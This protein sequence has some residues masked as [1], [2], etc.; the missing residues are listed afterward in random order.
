[1]T[2]GYGAHNQKSEIDIKVDVNLDNKIWI[3]D[4]VDIC[5]YAS[6]CA[7]YS[8]LKRGDEKYVTEASYMGKYI[9][10]DGNKY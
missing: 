4:L 2:A 9:D 6:S 10:N 3:E 7:T 5:K 8:T 1:M